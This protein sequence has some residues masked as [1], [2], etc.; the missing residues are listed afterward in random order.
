MEGARTRRW[1]ANCGVDWQCCVFASQ[2]C[3]TLCCKDCCI[4]D[5]CALC[6]GEYKGN[7]VYLREELDR[8]SAE[9]NTVSGAPQA[10]AM[11]R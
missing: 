1:R 4:A 3:C 8:H 5:P 9:K 11:E 7:M 10:D 6:L 2:S